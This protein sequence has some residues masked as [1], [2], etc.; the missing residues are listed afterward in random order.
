MR[1]PIAIEIGSDETAFGVVVPDLPGCFSA[2]D[3]LQIGFDLKVSGAT[4]CF[5]WPSRGMVA[6]Y[7]ADEA[8]I[9]ASE[10][11]IARFLLN[12]AARR[13]HGYF[14]QAEALLHDLA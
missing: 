13:G 11:A 12:F 7:P 14:A 10:G 9:E 1:Y 6:G 3:T 8:T 2:G 4:A 5:S